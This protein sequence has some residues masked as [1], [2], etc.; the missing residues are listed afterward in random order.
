MEF[1]RS[2]EKSVEA[3]SPSPFSN[4]AMLLTEGC[5]EARFCAAPYRL[6]PRRMRGP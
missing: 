3:K 2:N 6:P 5:Q 1:Q 4:P